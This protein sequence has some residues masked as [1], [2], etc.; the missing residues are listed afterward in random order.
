MNDFW[1]KC[2]VKW[3]KD[4]KGV[5]YLNSAENKEKVLS[6]HCKCP[7]ISTRPSAEEAK[8]RLTDDEHHFLKKKLRLS[9]KVGGISNPFIWMGGLKHWDGENFYKWGLKIY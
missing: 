1:T 6:I 4:Y 5:E 3:L 9:W 7:G 8:K 2:Q